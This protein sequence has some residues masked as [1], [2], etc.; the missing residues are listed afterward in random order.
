MQRARTSRCVKENQTQDACS[1]QAT[2]HSTQPVSSYRG[3]LYLEFL[4]V[5]LDLTT[6]TRACAAAFDPLYLYL[7]SYRQG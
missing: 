3:T 4:N 5:P 1:T 6:Y 2:Q 7:H